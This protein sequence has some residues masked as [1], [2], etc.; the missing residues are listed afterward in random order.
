MITSTLSKVVVCIEDTGDN[1]GPTGGGYLENDDSSSPLGE[2]GG[3]RGV[4]VGCLRVGEDVWLPLLLFE[5]DC[6]MLFVLSQKASK[7]GRVRYEG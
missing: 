7:V 3:F 2:S 5:K 1:G 4:Q 6:A